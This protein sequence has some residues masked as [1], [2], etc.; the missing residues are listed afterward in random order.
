[1]NQLAGDSNAFEQ[2]QVLEKIIRIMARTV[3]DQVEQEKKNTNAEDDISDKL[4]RPSTAGRPS[5]MKSLSAQRSISRLIGTPISA[6]RRISTAI[7]QRQIEHNIAER[8][9]ELSRGNGDMLEIEEG[10]ITKPHYFLSR[11]NSA[12][13]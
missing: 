4:N 2:S 7:N 1:M 9:D 13:H 8:F 10:I 12:S 3:K 11:K 6:N 5:M